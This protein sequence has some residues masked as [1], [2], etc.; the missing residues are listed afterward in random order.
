MSHSIQ[1]LPKGIC[2]NI[3]AVINQKAKGLSVNQNYIY[4]KTLVMGNIEDKEESSPRA[5]T[6]QS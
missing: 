1:S 2:P 6:A 3:N 4:L 5:G